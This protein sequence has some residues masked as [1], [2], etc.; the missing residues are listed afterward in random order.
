MSYYDHVR[1]GIWAAE[2]LAKSLG[3]DIS[4]ALNPLDPDDFVTISVR[5]AR[6]LKGAVAGAEGTALR[7]AIEGLDVDWP[8]LKE[9]ARD[10]IISEARAQVAGLSKTVP[11]LVEPVLVK[12]GGR[13]V[14][15]TRSAVVD[16]FEL[17]IK[18]AV[19]PV[20]TEMLKLLRGSQMAYVKDQYG[21]RSDAL[22][23]LTKKIV[24]SGLEQGLGRDDI[25]GALAEKLAEQQVLRSRAYWDFTATDFSNKA[26]TTTQLGAFGEAS[27]AH[28]VFEAIMDEVTSDICRL[29]HGRIFS[30]DKAITRT[31]SALEADD[32]EDVRSLRPWVQTG[33][34]GN[35]DTILYF[36]RGGERQ[37]VARIEASGVGRL[38]ETGR[39]SDVMSDKALEA[40]GLVIPPCHGHCRSNIMMVS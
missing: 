9:A 29:L 36:D 31:R 13:L 22:D 25:S 23:A 2:E 12:S 30:V 14:A 11:D 4:K 16:K 19:Q 24:A 28:W 35:G 15:S 1:E 39:Y 21:V 27:I 17:E 34:D 32:P 3:V 40:A 33:V 10:R 38:D 8:N 6:S 5:L 26:R 37:K 7:A 18:R 20:D